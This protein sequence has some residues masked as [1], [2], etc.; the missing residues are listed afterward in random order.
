MPPRGEALTREQVDLIRVWIDGGAQWPESSAASAG[1]TTTGMVVSQVD[2]NFWSFRPLRK[3]TPPKVQDEE[4]G[5]NPIDRLIRHEQEVRGLSPA[6]PAEARTLVRRIYFDLIGLPPELKGTGG[7]Y[8]ESVLGVELDLRTRR[9]DPGEYDRLVDR[10]LA[11][12]RHGERWAR[13]W[14]DIARYADSDGQEGD[15]DRPNAYRFRDF[16]IRSFNEDRPY[17][18][19][20]R[21]QIAG[22]EIAPDQP[23]AIAATGFLVAGNSTELNV[24]MEEEKLRNRA[25]ELDDMVST[26]GQAL[27]GL[28]VACARCHDH[29]YDPIPTRDYYRLMRIFNG[30]DRKDVPL[31]PPSEVRKH[32]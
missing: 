31:V 28:T 14:L 6:P 3:V 2:R 29:K 20:V 24:A 5:R 8:H 26:T 27:L 11:S 4:W 22:D 23:D 15:A 21:W 1:P 17:D 10:L 12:P 13:H 7:R 18:E 16:V 30:G 9:L 25:N 19:F 32:K